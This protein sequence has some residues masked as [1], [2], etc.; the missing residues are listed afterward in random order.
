[1]AR[2]FTHLLPEL[3]KGRVNDEITQKL[4]E[5]AQA[6][7]DTGKKGS[8]TLTLNVEPTGDG[9]AVKVKDALKAVVPEPDRRATLFFVGDDG[10]LSRSDPRQ[11]D[12]E[13]EL[14]RKRRTQAAE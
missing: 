4:A 11:T 2:S 5:V 10:E 6:V 14:E 9:A 1:M 8:V 7:I 13:D 3:Q 12:I